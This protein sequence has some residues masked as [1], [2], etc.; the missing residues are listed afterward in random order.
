MR[1]AYDSLV[2]LKAAITQ[3]MIL[4]GKHSAGF[5][6]PCNSVDHSTTEVCVNGISTMCLCQAPLV[7]TSTSLSTRSSYAETFQIMETTAVEDP[8]NGLI[9]LATARTIS[10]DILGSNH[11]SNIGTCL[12]TP[13][14]GLE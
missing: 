10:N 2:R 6:T 8:A 3:R 9:P 5:S 4:K 11:I 13:C 14:I 7:D 12:S 1:L